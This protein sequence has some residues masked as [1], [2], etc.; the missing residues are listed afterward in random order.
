MAAPLYDLLPPEDAFD[1]D[2]LLGRFLG[3]VAGKGLTLYPAQ[4][5]GR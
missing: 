3:Y 2:D 1:S 5:E 4:E